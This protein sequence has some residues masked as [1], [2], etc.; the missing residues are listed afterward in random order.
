MLGQK[1]TGDE[2]TAQPKA[3]KM[4]HADILK[5]LQATAP[6]KARG[7]QNQS[8]THLSTLLELARE[9]K[10]KSLTDLQWRAWM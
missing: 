3:S 9:E 5:E 6:N 10:E 1:R 8:K 2:V 7:K 4:K